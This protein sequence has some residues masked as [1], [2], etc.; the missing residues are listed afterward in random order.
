[1]GADRSAPVVGVPLSAGEFVRVLVELDPGVTGDLLPFDL[2]TVNLGEQ[3]L[4][5]FAVLHGFSSRRLPAVTLPALTTALGEG[6]QHVAGVDVDAHP[7][8]RG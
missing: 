3:L 7:R 8:R 4:P 2:V 6:V 1:M 5:Q